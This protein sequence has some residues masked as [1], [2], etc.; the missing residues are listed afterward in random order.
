[1]EDVLSL[2]LG[3]RRSVVALSLLVGM[4]GGACSS[5]ADSAPTTL[6]TDEP[7]ATIA[8]GD[9]WTRITFGPSLGLVGVVEG[10][11][12]LVAVGIAPGCGVSTA[13][14][15]SSEGMIVL[16]SPDGLDW[17]MEAQ[18]PEAFSKATPATLLSTGGGL[19]ILGDAD[20]GPLVMTSG[21]G[22]SWTT[23][24]SQTDPPVGLGSVV[25]GT[26][27]WVATGIYHVDPDWHA[28]VLTSPDARAW[29]RVPHDSAVFL[30][31]AVLGSVVWGDDKFVTV[32][33]GPVGTS[34]QAT[35]VATSTDGV[36]W[37]RVPHQE[38][39]FGNSSMH[40]VT[41]MGSGF[42]A[43]GV[44][45]DGLNAVVLVSPDGTTWTRVPHNEAVFGDA[46][47]DSVTETSDGVVA[48]GSTASF[49][50]AV[51]W[52]SPDGLTWTKIPHDAV[53]FDDGDMNQI[54]DTS[55]GLLIAGENAEGDRGVIWIWQPAN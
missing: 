28:A 48:V 25:F 26:P 13:V 10:G 37:V 5:G 17:S 27:G 45:A 32:G 51:V 42:V 39:V 7:V 44:T 47:I 30:E 16:T 3:L 52:T 36:S 38:E 31:D 29:T 22:V 35:V 46:I 19:M 11:P 55:Y 18:Y 54:T 15:E 4:V 1:M 2:T 14:C 34:A 50:R 8:V 24:P 20:P 49:D 40:S 21:D 43:G 12:G 53:L 23:L 6:A 33:R 9:G 41:P